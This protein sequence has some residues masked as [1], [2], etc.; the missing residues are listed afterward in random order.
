MSENLNKNNLN[1]NLDI[2]NLDAKVAELRG[3]GYGCSQVVMSIGLERLKINSPEIISAMEGYCGGAC[4]GTCGALCGGGG[5]LGFYLGK[6]RHDEKR[7]ASL[8]NLVKELTQGFNTKW[9]AVT[10]DGLI[11]GDDNAHKNTCPKLMADTVRR[12]WAI[13]ENHGISPDSRNNGV[14]I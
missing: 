5:L 4:G 12:V 14:G 7:S 10:C 9:G 2:N 8:K 13:L 11:H 6:G 1:N 3:Y